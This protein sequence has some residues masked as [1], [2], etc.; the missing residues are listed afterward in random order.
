[1]NISKFSIQRPVVTM[2]II[3]SMTILGLLTLINLKTELMPN[4]NLPTARIRVRWSG[5]SPDDMENL[6]TRKIE[7]GIA[8]VEGIK[9]V[10]TR[11]KMDYSYL[12]VEFDYGVNIDNKVNDLTTAVN[13]IR[14]DLPEDIDEPIVNKTSFSSSIILPCCFTLYKFY[15]S[16]Y[17]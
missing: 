4:A 15:T 14:N 8:S 10:T 2:M 12:S 9:R 1:M 5:A 11:S 7:D 17:F 16:M 13:R 6:V 3:I